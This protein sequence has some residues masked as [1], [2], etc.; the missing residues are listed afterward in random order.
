MAVFI[1]ETDILFSDVGQFFREGAIRPL[2]KLLL[3][4][5]GSFVLLHP[6]FMHLRVITTPVDEFRM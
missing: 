4:L 1:P 2:G 3:A 5:N 6:G